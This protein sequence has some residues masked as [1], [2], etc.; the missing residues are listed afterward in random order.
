MRDFKIY[1]K[2]KE[3]IYF[4]LFIILSLLIS[5]ITFFFEKFF[6]GSSF[7]KGNEST[8]HFFTNNPKWIVWLFMGFVQ[9]PFC[10]NLVQVIIKQIK[11]I[12]L[13]FSLKIESVTQNSLKTLQSIQGRATGITSMDKRYYDL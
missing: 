3:T 5:G 10:I 1:Q 2:N 6:G 7:G 12:H 13:K 4:V 9:V 8:I 11:E